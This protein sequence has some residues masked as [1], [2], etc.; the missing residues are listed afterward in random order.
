VH[1]GSIPIPSPQG[2]RDSS[3]DQR[4]MF[5]AFTP[6]RR[7]WSA[8]WAVPVA[9][10]GVGGFDEYPLERAS[11][12]LRARTSGP[13]L[14]F[15]NDAIAPIGPGGLGWMSY[16]YNNS[17]TATFTIGRAAPPEEP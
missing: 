11:N 5:A 7:V 15:L 16:Y 13:I 2:F 10:I 1:D 14:L 12:T 17:G 9:R 6:F 8:D 3:L 4:L